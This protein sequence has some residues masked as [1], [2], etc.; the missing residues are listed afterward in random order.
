MP[1]KNMKA[2]KEYEARWREENKGYQKKWSKQNRK[3]CR[4]YVK[5]WREKNKAHCAIKMKERRDRFPWENH[6]YMAK[7]RCENKKNHKYPR[8]GGRGIKFKLT[9]TQIKSVWFRDNASEL[10]RPS[11]DRID[12]NGNYELSNI[13]FIEFTKNTLKG[14]K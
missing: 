6:F 12:N 13:R 7:Q 14:A 10:R 3:K 11:I 2:K 1:W 9:I 8:Y 5:K 4:A